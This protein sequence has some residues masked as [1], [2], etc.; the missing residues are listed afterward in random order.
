MTLAD[1]PPY[2]GIF[3]NFFKF[4]FW[5][6][7]LWHFSEWKDLQKIWKLYFFLG[8]FEDKYY[9][10]GHFQSLTPTRDNPTL[11]CIKQNGGY[12]VVSYFNFGEFCLYFFKGEF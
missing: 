11:Q 2:Y 8:Y 3:H 12:D 9:S 4:F 1:P 6:L 7:P 5:T 10:A